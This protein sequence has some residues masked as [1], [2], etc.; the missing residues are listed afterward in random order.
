MRVL[1]RVAEQSRVGLAMKEWL[2]RVS[3]AREYKRLTVMSCLLSIDLSGDRLESL[4]SLCPVPCILTIVLRMLQEQSQVIRS[5]LMFR[6][7]WE[8]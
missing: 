6:A 3:V 5:W 1:G 7:S 4:K 8:R 2:P